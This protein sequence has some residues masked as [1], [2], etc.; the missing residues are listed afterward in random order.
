MGAVDDMKHH[1]HFEYSIDV[2]AETVQPSARAR[3]RARPAT[4]TGAAWH[5]SFDGDVGAF[6][7]PS[8]QMYEGLTSPSL[9]GSRAGAPRPGGVGGA[10]PHGP[11]S[12]RPKWT[13]SS[14]HPTETAKSDREKR[15]VRLMERLA[16]GERC[17]RAHSADFKGAARATGGPVRPVTASAASP[18]LDSAASDIE[19][20]SRGMHPTTRTVYSNLTADAHMK[21]DRAMEKLGALDAAEKRELE[22]V[23]QGAGPR[24][25]LHDR[26]LREAETLHPQL[27]ISHFQQR[28]A[29]RSAANAATEKKGLQQVRSVVK[30]LFGDQALQRNAQVR[31]ADNDEASDDHADTSAMSVRRQRE[32]FYSKYHMVASSEHLVRKKH[33]A[34]RLD[35]PRSP[36][37]RRTRQRGHQTT[38][39]WRR[40]RAPQTE[41]SGSAATDSELQHS[42]RGKYLQ[43]CVR[44]TLVP[45]RL[46]LRGARSEHA[47]ARKASDVSTHSDAERVSGQAGYTEQRLLSTDPSCDANDEPEPPFKLDPDDPAFAA[48]KRASALALSVAPTSR[49]S[50]PGSMPHPSLTIAH[51]GIGNHLAN[52]MAV[53]IPDALVAH[54]RDEG[55]PAFVRSLDLS[56]NRLDCDSLDSVLSQ[57]A[58][59]HSANLETLRLDGNAL[60]PPVNQDNDEADLDPTVSPPTGMETIT[61]LCALVRG[62]SALLSLRRLELAGTCLGLGGIHALTDAVCGTHARRVGATVAPI[63]YLDI[64]RNALCDAAGVSLARM[65]G[66]HA[67]TLKTVKAGWNRLADDAAQELG[68]AISLNT[69]LTE[70]DLAANSFGSATQFIARALPLNTTLWR[71]DL[72]HNSVTAEAALVLGYALCRCQALQWLGLSSNPLGYD[73]GRAILRALLRGIRLAP[74]SGN[75]GDSRCGEALSPEGFDCA[76]VELGGCIFTRQPGAGVRASGL[77]RMGKQAHVR[78]LFDPKLPEVGAPYSL[79]LSLPVDFV[80]TSELLDAVSAGRD[81]GG[82]VGTGARQCGDLVGS[83]LIVGRQRQSMRFERGSATV[84]GIKDV[85]V[86][87]DAATGKPWLIPSNGIF[88][89]DFRSHRRTKVA[90]LSLGRAGMRRLLTLVAAGKDAMTRRDLLRMALVDMVLMPEQAQQ[91]VD[92]V[93]HLLDA[94]EAVALVLPA[95]AQ[96]V[97]PDAVQLEQCPPADDLFSFLR[98]N[99]HPSPSDGGMAKVIS[100]VGFPAFRFDA[101][102]A[103]GLWRLDLKLPQHHELAT[104]LGVIADEEA[105]DR[106]AQDKDP[107]NAKLPSGRS[108]DTSQKRGWL[109]FRNE[110]LNG[111]PIDLSLE[112]FERL[113]RSG[114]LEFDYVSTRRPSAASVAVLDA[115]LEADLKHIGI[116]SN[117]GRRRIHDASDTA[118]KS[119]GG[120]VISGILLHFHLFASYRYFTCSQVLGIMDKVSERAQPPGGGYD[121]GGGAAAAAKFCGPLH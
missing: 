48:G 15:S 114:L 8:L 65:L 110:K 51:F 69:S 29:R 89:T 113:P 19:R 105:H 97:K 86:C 47:A 81:D 4:A 73:G 85:A 107:R 115:D 100:M 16:L 17:L 40:R 83:C 91:I 20:F 52:A 2:P 68:E 90:A 94:H 25:E 112:F 9:R 24:R 96:C 99:Y 71:L 22:L 28:A 26:R 1:R 103:T 5:A 59:P 63:E 49:A 57:L 36:S 82:A 58:G 3:S 46:L 44:N 77:T 93:G 45:E 53:S 79:N 37:V 11:A 72:S 84:A 6:R 10:V 7:Y 102:N 98:R 88:E 38:S 66:H 101:H 118:A 120:T 104:R 70:F 43:Q 13:L 119:D 62:R 121:S 80:I 67:C 76:E 117:L 50:E 56:N 75:N 34:L 42:P 92:G 87:I 21:L 111:E 23:L 33:V 18:S 116:D 74:T 106:H 60:H 95:A 41:G 78:A 55:A 12:F 64:S 61:R 39:T 108:C 54:T 35:D 32:A 31:P 109:N 30:E 27:A 14:A